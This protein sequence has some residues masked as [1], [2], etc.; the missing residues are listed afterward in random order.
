MFSSA[1]PFVSLDDP[2]VYRPPSER[3]RLAIF[4]PLLLSTVRVEVDAW[5]RSNVVDPPLKLTV[6]SANTVLPVPLASKVRSP[7]APVAIVNAPLSAILFV[8]NV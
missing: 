3:L 5:V 6:V 8:V 4:A 1:P 2:P 7:L